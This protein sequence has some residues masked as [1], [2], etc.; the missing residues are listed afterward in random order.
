MNPRNTGIL[1]LV[2][3][4]LGA[5]V[6]FYVVEGEEGRNEAEERE[7][8]LFADV[9]AE[10]ID[11]IALVTSDDVSVRAER[12]GEDGWQIVRPLAF[13]GDAF[14]LDALAAALAQLSSEAIYESPQLLEVYGLDD[15]TREVRFGVGDTDHALRT[16]SDTPIGS[17][18]YATVVGETP[19]YTIPRFRATAFRKSF[20][21]LRDKRILSFDQAAVERVAVSWPDGRVD[22]Q[23]DDE[24]WKL[25]APLE[26]AAD[27][28][29]ARDLL[30]DLS[31]LRAVGFEDTPPPDEQTGLDRP[32]LAVEL[33]VAAEGEGEPRHLS[34]AIGSAVDGEHR[35]VRAG[36]PSLYR[37]P[38]ERLGD[39]ERDVVAYR[40]KELA[41][42]APADA[43]RIELVFHE[44]GEELTVTAT[45]G[46]SGWTSEPEAMAPEKITR[47]AET[48]SHLSAEDIL[49]EQVG[50]DELG[51]LELDP[52]NVTL[53]VSGGGEAD[54]ETRLAEV[55]LGAI[56]T[57]GGVV[58][59]TGENPQVFELAIELGEFVPL[60]LQG[61]RN[62]FRTS[63]PE[64]EEPLMSEADPEADL[65][66]EE[67][68]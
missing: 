63:E 32:A 25:V 51:G 7:K 17:N 53:V 59:Q 2:A 61:F 49:A 26:A 34:F 24:D 35:F 38:V 15:V 19:V 42:F 54:P 64:P 23:R 27:A 48:L 55:R 45:R 56:R 16:G 33:T 6:W 20:D 67:A 62:H 44:A 37:I 40:F 58:A 30:S 22:L 28:Q 9:E 10:Q 60:N 12:Q 29:A 31:F 65:G 66:F 39:F 1:F 36:Q 13:P 4:A 68:P 14:T 52:A 8:R 46:E 47:L 3:A 21:D 5:F 11:W 57:G 41:S 50:P 18:A 43:K